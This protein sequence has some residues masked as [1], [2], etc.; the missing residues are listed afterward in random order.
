MCLVAGF[1][2]D[3]L[4][5]P[6]CSTRKECPSQHHSDSIMYLILTKRIKN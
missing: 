3:L 1:L 4:W 2:I 6:A 5:R